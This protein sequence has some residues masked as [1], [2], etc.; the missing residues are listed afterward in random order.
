MSVSAS[1]DEAACKREFR[2]FEL[3][4]KGE[5]A[6]FHKRVRQHEKYLD[7]VHALL[8]GSCRLTLRDR[9]E[10]Q[11]GLEEKIRNNPIELLLAI[12]QSAL[13]CEESMAWVLVVTDAHRACFNCKQNY[14]K[15]LEDQTRRHKAARDILYS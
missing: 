4:C 9:I 14:N 15:E 3:D 2:E 11:S 10:D 1:H 7:A 6:D 5:S 13:G 12:K 8:W